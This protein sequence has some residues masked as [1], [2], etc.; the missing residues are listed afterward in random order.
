MENSSLRI[1]IV[2][3]N[4]TNLKVLS[5]NLS[6][7]GYEL[8][9]ANTGERAIAIAKRAKPELI[10]LDINLPGINGFETCRT[11]KKDKNTEDI[12]IIFLS[13]LD[14]VNS[15][16]EGFRSGGV[17]YITKPF[18]KDEVLVRVATQL[19]IH[20]LQKKL[21]GQNQALQEAQEE[22]EAK[23]ADLEY[24]NKEITAGITYARRIQ[25]AIL[26]DNRLIKKALPNSFIFYRSKEIVSGDFYWFD[27]IGTKA[28]LSA[29]DC[30]GHGVPG[31]FMTV[32]GYTQLNH[33]VNELDLIDPGEILTELD[34][35]IQ[36]V[37][38]QGNKESTTQDGMDLSLCVFDTYNKK[39][40][41]SNA[42]RP[43]YLFRDG[44]LQKFKGDRNPIGGTQVKDKSFSTQS[45]NIQ[46]GDMIYF[47]T[48]GY[49][50]QFGG[51]KGKRLMTRNFV[52]LLNEIHTL[53]VEEQHKRLGDNFDAWKGDVEQTDDVLVIGVKF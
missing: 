39:L 51:E 48:D 53:D 18:Y 22:L 19:K 1:L 37:L 43:L 24:I 20:K 11:L 14:D 26:P 2:D 36:T 8:L 32:I 7:S 33:I 16:L 5:S 34:E 50:D 15:K 38:K 13:A 17:D 27:Q 21:E 6:G 46:D 45:V 4:P 25:Q 23:R 30:T 29:I 49:P 3:D 10:L 44:E 12:P 52:N 42:M 41:F 31:A 35:R 9:I 28:I 47:F 40:E